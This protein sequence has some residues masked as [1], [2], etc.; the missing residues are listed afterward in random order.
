MLIDTMGVALPIREADLSAV[1][2]DTLMLFRLLKSVVGRFGPRALGGHVISM[3]KH[4]SDVLAITWLWNQANRVQDTVI[5]SEQIAMVPLFETIED[6]RNAPAI[7]ESLLNTPVYREALAKEGNRQTIMLGYSDSTKDGGYLTACWSI[8]ECQHTLQRLANELGVELV[9]FHGRGG[10]L[11]RG[12]GPAARSILS[13]PREAFHGALRLTEQGEVLAERY[14]DSRI[15]HRHLEQLIWSSLLASATAA[16]STPT[17]WFAVMRSLA[18]RSLSAYRS[19][20]EHPG[21][22]EFF[23]GATPINEIEQLPIGSRPSRRRGGNSLSEL[24]AIPWVFSWT[25]SRFLLPAWYGLGSAFAEELGGP[26]ALERLQRMYREWPFFKATID[27]AE[28]ALAKTDMGIA[29]GYAESLPG[30]D[31]QEIWQQIKNEYA[32][33]KQ[34]VLAITNNEHLLDSIHWLQESISV[35]NWYVDP[36]NLIQMELLR[37]LRSSLQE[38]DERSEDSEELRHLTRLTIKGI[39][40]GMRTTG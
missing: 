14:D 23:R 13:L 33:A 6:L 24:R 2:Q 35:R 17:E 29:G 25:Q 10:S 20:V 28:L 30:T 40:A 8:Y 31:D 11:G 4:P 37:R 15:A 3:T 26:M 19:L 22:V 12:G 36:L 16:D 7:L 39:T 18:E 21:F 1:A 5:D 38:G 34:A 32:Q 27:N 9:F